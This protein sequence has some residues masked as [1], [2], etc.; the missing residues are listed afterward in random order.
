MAPGK[1]ASVEG[2]RPGPQQVTLECGFHQVREDGLGL[3]EAQGTGSDT[4]L[5]SKA[6]L[7]DRMRIKSQKNQTPGWRC[8]YNPG[9]QL[10]AWPGSRADGVNGFAGGGH[11][12]TFR[13]YVQGHTRHGVPVM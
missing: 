6:G 5:Q 1:R 3:L 4:S 8:R 13:I 9:F 7:R 2:V 11:R 12:A 10:P